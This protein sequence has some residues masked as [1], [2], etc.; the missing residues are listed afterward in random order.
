MS[1]SP[2]APDGSSNEAPNQRVGKAG[3]SARDLG[4]RDLSALPEVLPDGSAARA[5]VKAS[6][7]VGWSGSSCRSG[8]EHSVSARRRGLTDGV[9]CSWS[10]QGI[11]GVRAVR[12]ST[13]SAP[14]LVRFGCGSQSLRVSLLESKSVIRLSATYT[15]NATAWSGVGLNGMSLVSHNNRT[16]NNGLE[17][18]RSRSNGLREPCRSTQCS[19][20]VENDLW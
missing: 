17:R 5:V 20:G 9:G 15:S 14:S 10:R 4:A 2:A 11:V 8:C 3:L 1:F 13:R 18:T 12:A 19:T 7:V 16:H 6:S